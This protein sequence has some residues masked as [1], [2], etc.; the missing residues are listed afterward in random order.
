MFAI[1]HAHCQMGKISNNLEKHGEE[2]VPAWTIPIVGV[3]VDA[4]TLCTLLHD[5]FGSDAF[6]MRGKDGVMEP[7]A[8]TTHA[9]PIALTEAYDGM[10]TKIVMGDEFAD[11]D[12]CRL[13]ELTLGR[14]FQGGM[15]QVDLKLQLEP[16]LARENL[17]LQEYQNQPI[18]LTVEDAKVA[19]K[20]K[21]RQQEL[22]LVVT[23]N[24]EAKAEAS[25]HPD[26]DATNGVAADDPLWTDAVS[27]VRESRISSISGLQMQLKIGYNRAALLMGAMEI[28]GIVGPRKADGSREIL[29]A[30]TPPPSPLDDAEQPGDDDSDTS[31]P[32][33]DDITEQVEV[34][35]KRETASAPPQRRRGR[36]KKNAGNGARAH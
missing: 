17:V 12:R 29:E 16:G 1:D 14:F 8:W 19:A 28:A 2:D 20:K 34:V 13:K 7:R 22:P 26:P 33:E 15:T 10:A 25:A 21:L 9:N 3:M 6:F 4:V 30:E 24:G 32:D 11:F 35:E 18:V 36:P 23:A 31:E 5:P 27:F